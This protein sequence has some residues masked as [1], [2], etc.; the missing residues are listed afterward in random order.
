MDLGHL[1]AWLLPPDAGE[2][3]ILSKKGF[4]ELLRPREELVKKGRESA[5]KVV[6]RGTIVDVEQLWEALEG[7]WRTAPGPGRR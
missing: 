6:N 5:R 4:E 7:G 1:P 3:I 2:T